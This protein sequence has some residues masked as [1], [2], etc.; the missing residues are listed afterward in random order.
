MRMK[1]WR[2]RVLCAAA[3]GSALAAV[4][5]YAAVSTTIAS[6]TIDHT[7]LVGGPAT[8]LIRTLTIGP[9]EV[10]G[11]HHHPGIGAITIVKQG[12][13]TVEDGCGG[14]TVYTAG[15]AFVEPPGRVHRGKNL[16]ES[17]EVITAQA[18]VVPFGAATSIS[19]ARLC[20]AP[21]DILE[22][23]GGGWA[24]FNHPQPFSNQG[25]CEQFVI[26]GK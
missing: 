1:S 21:A 14:E 24:Q 25:D 17:T 16:D 9:N 19:T 5:V 2:N 4:T 18:F 13:L 15:M 7:D 11:W 23:R 12:T 6:G 22:C 8:T 20:G 3:A 26:T 10:L